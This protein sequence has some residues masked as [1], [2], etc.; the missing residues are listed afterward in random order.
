MIHYFPHNS[1][2]LIISEVLQTR[3]VDRLKVY[4]EAEKRLSKDNPP[5]YSA[6]S[7]TGQTEKYLVLSTGGRGSVN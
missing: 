2:P 3:R 5:N 4:H 6:I 7:S 1:S